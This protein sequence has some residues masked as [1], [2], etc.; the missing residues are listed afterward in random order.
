MEFRLLNCATFRPYFPPVV[1]ATNCLLVRSGSSLLLVDSG[2]G[3]RDR[4]EPTRAMKWFCR[5]SRI[6]S[7][8][9][10]TAIRQIQGL[11]LGPSDVKHIVL[12]HLHIDHA[13]GLPDFP[14]AIVHVHRTEYEA[15]MEATGLARIVYRPEHWSHEPRWLIH[16]TRNTSGWF[17]LDSIPVLSDELFEVLLI[18]LAGHSAGHCGVAIKGDMKWVLHCGDALPLGGF[19]SNPPEWI[20]RRLIGPHVKRLKHLAYEHRDEVQ[21]LSSHMPLGSESSRIWS[22]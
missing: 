14:E 11:G 22:S 16:E 4:V 17:G 2:L 12:T 15:A 18:P 13:G 20:T 10:E 7:D 6:P 5:L 21:I 9:N 3:V 1:S 8:P 19:E